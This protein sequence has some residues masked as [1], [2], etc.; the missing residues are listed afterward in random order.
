MTARAAAM[1]WLSGS[2]AANCCSQAGAPSSENQTPER[3]I[4]GMLM[5]LSS[6]LA[7]SS[8]WMRAATS[9]PRDAMDAP[10]SRAIN[11]NSQP[12]PSSGTPSKK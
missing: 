11:S 5:T 6:P 1:I 4:I 2:Q 12:E 7:S 3:N 9:R 8:F 10:P